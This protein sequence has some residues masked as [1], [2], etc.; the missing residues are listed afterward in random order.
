MIVARIELINFFFA[1]VLALNIIIGLYQDI[2]ARKLID[3]LKV[4][5]SIKVDVLRD[6]KIQPIK[7]HQ[8]VLSDIVG[9]GFTQ[10]AKVS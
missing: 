5:S 10:Y 6:G 1:G 2:R 7:A 8:L 9:D 4:V 3:K